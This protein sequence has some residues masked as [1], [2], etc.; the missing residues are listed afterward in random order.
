MV[1]VADGSDPHR[2]GH[3][4][5]VPGRPGKT[6]K[7][8]RAERAGPPSASP[9]GGGPPSVA[10][11]RPTSRGR[12]TRTRILDA[13]V[14]LVR[15]RGAVATSVDQILERA[16]AGKSQFYHYFGSKAGLVEEVIRREL[17]ARLSAQARYLEDL[18]SLTGI[19]RWFDSLAEE[20]EHEG[21][22]GC[23]PIG[24]LAVEL[25][26]QADEAA[27]AYLAAAFDQIESGL[28]AGLARMKAAGR[29]RAG[30]DPDALAAVA[31][32]A[33]RGGLLAAHVRGDPGELRRVLD[34]LLDCLA[35]HAAPGRGSARTLNA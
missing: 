14:A 24:C 18:D 34:T 23:D 29:L 19:E 4:L 35:A 26:G 6:R 25:R 21:Y 2:P 1:L 11:P 9:A 27:G 15:E 10:V 17:E 30:V 32:S 12:T 3:R 8:A 31:W 7:R 13:A 22:A 5:G 28:R 20:Y 33:I 16:R